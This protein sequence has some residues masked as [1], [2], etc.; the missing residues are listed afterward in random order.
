MVAG[1]IIESI[2]AEFRRDRLSNPDGLIERLV[3][4]QM[5]LLG[6]LGQNPE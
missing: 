5:A 2:G 3:M 4:L 1:A 6:N